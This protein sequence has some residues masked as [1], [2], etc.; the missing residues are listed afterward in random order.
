VPLPID[1]CAHNV[2]TQVCCS[3]IWDVAE[4]IRC[5]AYDAVVCC[6]DPSCADQEFRSY[7]SIGT[8]VPEPLGDALV[9]TMVDASPSTASRSPTGMLLGAS[10]QE[11]RF[12]AYLT[13]NGWPMPIAD[14]VGEV[15]EVPDSWL[16]NAVARHA[17]SH[18]ERM[19]RAILDSVQRKEMFPVSTFPHI[20]KVDVAGLEPVPPRAFAVG[21]VVPVTV[22]M[23]FP[24]L[25]AEVIGS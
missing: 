18:G 9:V 19:Y 5:I 2:P 8:D 23:T 11:V 24:P 22:Q 10:L 15:I 25:I 12:E 20:A 14:E 16:I 7:V 1:A 17:Y 6:I 21:W 3:G 13:E 4:R